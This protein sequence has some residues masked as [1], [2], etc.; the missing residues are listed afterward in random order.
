MKRFYAI[1][2][3]GHTPAELVAFPIVKEGCND[4]QALA[5]YNAFN[6]VQG[7]ICQV[8]VKPDTRWCYAMNERDYQMHLESEKRLAKRLNEA[9]QEREPLELADIWAFYEH[10]GYDYKTKKFKDSK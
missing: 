8:G 4:Y 10:V 7:K 3:N 2:Y 9:Y 1:V 6:A 5:S